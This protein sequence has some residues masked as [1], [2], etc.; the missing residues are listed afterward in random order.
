M[1]PLSGR[2]LLIIYR[3]GPRTGAAVKTGG[4]GVI[5]IGDGP[6]GVALFG[7]TPYGCHSVRKRNSRTTRER[8][9]KGCNIIYIRET[10]IIICPVPGR[11]WKW[12]GGR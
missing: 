10:T 8:T 2:W 12:G 1:G 11:R 7:G 5:F 6:R 3:Y 9:P 4:G